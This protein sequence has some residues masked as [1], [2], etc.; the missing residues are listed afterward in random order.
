M[1]EVND[2]LAR[3]FQGAVQPDAG[4]GAL[5]G[6]FN[7]DGSEDIAVVVKPAA[8]RLE[9]INA[10]VANWILG[11]A[12]KAVLP[13]PT[14]A[15]QK[16]PAAER[17][18]VQPGDVLLAVIHGY[19]QAGWRNPEAQQAY[20]LRNAAG[21]EP[22]VEPR[23]EAAEEFK[24]VIP[25]LNADIIREEI[26]GAPGFVYWAGGKYAWFAPAKRGAK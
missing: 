16:L 19:Q 7:G 26:G 10:E 20:L 13:D 5:V 1:S 24:A 6:D 9:E 21:R 17:V 18:R 15:V 8:D 14:K 12:Q 11:D 25:H 23:R 22:R 4:V 2:K 3:I